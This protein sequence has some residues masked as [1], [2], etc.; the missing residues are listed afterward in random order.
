MSASSYTVQ[1]TMVNSNT[2]MR[3]FRNKLEPTS[4]MEE[5]FIEDYGPAIIRAARGSWR[6]GDKDPTFQE[7]ISYLL[8]TPVEQY[9]EHWQP[10]A[11]KCRLGDCEN[12]SEHEN[13][14]FRYKNMILIFQG[15]SAPL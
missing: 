12:I 9:D 14:S 4:R 2:E 8:Q 5:G 10:I 13:N 6:P 11:L 15:V 3:M 1:C 7:F